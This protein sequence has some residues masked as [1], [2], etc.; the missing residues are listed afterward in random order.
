MAV[1]AER[2]TREGLALSK[3]PPCTEIASLASQFPVMRTCCKNAGAQDAPLSSLVGAAV[4]QGPQAERVGIQ[5][6]VLG[7]TR[8]S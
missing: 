5:Q 4:I 1:P 8:Q 3:E 7:R 2:S 6:R